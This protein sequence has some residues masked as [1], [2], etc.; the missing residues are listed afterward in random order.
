VTQQLT[1]FREKF[2]PGPYLRAVDLATGRKVWDYPMGAGRST[3]ALATA[4][5]LVLLGGRGGIVALDAGNGGELWHVDVS[6]TQCDGVCHEASAMTYMVGGKQYIAMSGYGVVLGYTLSDV[7]DDSTAPSPPRAATTS[8]S[9]REIAA[10]PAGPG[11][12]IAVRACSTCHAPAV[13]AGQRRTRDA[14]DE[15]MRR[16]TMRGLALSPSEYDAVLSYLA[17]HFGPP[18]K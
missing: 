10:L 5:N 6:Q 14:W 16:M 4:G 12:E 2:P 1:A 11:K 9:A 17:T 7:P 8:T 13:W 3:G 18:P 15:T